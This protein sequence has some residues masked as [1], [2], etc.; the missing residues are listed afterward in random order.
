MKIKILKYSRYFLW[1]SPKL[2]KDITF[3]IRN[4][5]KSKKLSTFIAN[6]PDCIYTENTTDSRDYDPEYIVDQQ[7]TYDFEFYG[8]EDIV[9]LVD[10]Q[11]LNSWALKEYV[12]QQLD[13]NTVTHGY[14][15]ERPWSHYDHQVNVSGLTSDAID[16][17]KNDLFR[18][19][20]SF[21]SDLVDEY[22]DELEELRN[23]Y[24]DEYEDEDEEDI[25]ESMNQ[26][27]ADDDYTGNI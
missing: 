2:K 4:L 17:I 21:W 14:E 18:D 8:S 13:Y 3:E 23:E 24:D 9:Q 16:F 5:K 19:V 27:A 6:N 10:A 25:D 20:D 26:L 12:E 22:A 7:P 15:T 1:F 11:L